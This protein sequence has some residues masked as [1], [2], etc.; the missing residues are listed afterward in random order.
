MLSVASKSTSAASSP[1]PAAAKKLPDPTNEDT[2]LLYEQIDLGYTT[3]SRVYTDFERGDLFYKNPTTDKY[4]V[5]E[6]TYAP[7]PRIP[8][9][10]L[11]DLELYYI[12]HPVSGDFLKLSGSRDEV[13][14][15]L[16]RKASI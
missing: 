12:D 13:K 4:E 11:E 7:I 10:R 5:F 14:G 9:F 8:V 3:V 6:P 16:W 15:K 2:K 1:A